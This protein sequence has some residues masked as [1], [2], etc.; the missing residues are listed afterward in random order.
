MVSKEYTTRKKATYMQ[1][2]FTL[3]VQINN[4]ITKSVNEL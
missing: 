2:T 4:K 1:L 3:C